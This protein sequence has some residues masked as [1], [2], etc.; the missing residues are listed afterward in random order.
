[1]RRLTLIDATSLCGRSHFIETVERQSQSSQTRE[2][3]K[4]RRHPPR[5]PLP[6]P[7]EAWIA[8]ECSDPL[9]AQV[10]HTDAICQLTLYTEVRHI[11]PSWSRPN[12]AITTRDSEEAASAVWLI[13]LGGT[14]FRAC[15]YQR[16]GTAGRSLA[17]R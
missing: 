15:V 12:T 4:R 14:P 9:R 17:R 10:A 13:L 7:V 11:A 16:R 3:G 1:M 5:H 8:S 6:S 2:N